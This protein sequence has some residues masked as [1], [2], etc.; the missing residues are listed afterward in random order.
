MGT[1]PKQ[2]LKDWEAGYKS[3]R[4]V[5][6]RKDGKFVEEQIRIARPN[7]LVEVNIPN[8]ILFESIN[9]CYICT[10]NWINGMMIYQQEDILK[11]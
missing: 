4:I 8:V 2:D 5:L 6:K 1:D 7:K 9:C 11:L 3:V 10:G